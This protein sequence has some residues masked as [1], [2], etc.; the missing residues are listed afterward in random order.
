MSYQ[1]GINPT[2]GPARGDV[3]FVPIDIFASATAPKRLVTSGLG[4]VLPPGITLGRVVKLEPSTAGLFK[5]GE[6]ELD[7]MLSELIEVTVLVPLTT[8]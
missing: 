4:G 5:T 7:P 3:E 1:G 2:F 8:D 6:I